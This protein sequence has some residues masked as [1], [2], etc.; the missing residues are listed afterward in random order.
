M[1]MN[2]RIA[3][4]VAATRFGHC[5]VQRGV[6]AQR[7]Q[8]LNIRRTSLAQGF[9]NIGNVGHHQEFLQRK[10]RRHHSATPR[11]IGAVLMPAIIEP[12]VA[13]KLNNQVQRHNMEFAFLQARQCEHRANKLAVP[14]QPVRGT[15]SAD[16]LRALV[17]QRVIPPLRRHNSFFESA[18]GIRCHPHAER[19]A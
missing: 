10:P 2:V 4:L 6:P 11:V 15:A 18:A 17:N 1:G 16:R 3:M 5:F 12:A 13:R 19:A 9:A 8:H 7:S 14:E